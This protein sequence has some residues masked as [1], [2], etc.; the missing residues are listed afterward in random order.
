M[1]RL[2][3]KLANQLMKKGQI[4]IDGIEINLWQGHTTYTVNNSL[5]WNKIISYSELNSHTEGENGDLVFTGVMQIPRQEASEYAV[6]I[7][8]N[9]RQ[10]PSTNTDFIIIGSE[11][12]SPSKIAKALQLN[13]KACDIKFI[14]ETTF[15]S[16]V[17]EHLIE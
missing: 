13:K 2:K 8:F 17:S 16:L 12:V 1:K 15:L 4:I 11:N 9:V 10:Q 5:T 14:D 7:G 3:N 6:K